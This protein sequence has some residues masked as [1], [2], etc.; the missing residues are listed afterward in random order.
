MTHLHFYLF[1][2]LH[3]VCRRCSIYPPPSYSTLLI[4][5]TSLHIL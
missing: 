4:H 1:L 2:T 5:H 3:C